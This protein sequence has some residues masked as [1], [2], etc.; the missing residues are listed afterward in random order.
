MQTHLDCHHVAPLEC[1]NASKINS[2]KK[3]ITLTF[4]GHQLQLYQHPLLF[5][6]AAALEA[7][8]RRQLNLDP[9]PEPKTAS[10]QG[11]SRLQDF[12]RPNVLVR[13]YL[14]QNDPTFKKLD[15]LREEVVFSPS[16]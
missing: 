11:L 16:D 8:I 5:I 10:V 9:L 2:N 1:D 6:M 4:R 13:E 12:L 15:S 7:S 14:S 3:A